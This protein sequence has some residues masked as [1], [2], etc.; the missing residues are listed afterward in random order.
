[1]DTIS[2]IRAEIERLKDEYTDIAIDSHYGTVN[3]NHVVDDLEQLL[4]FLDTIESEELME[5]EKEVKPC[6]RT[7]NK[8]VEWSKTPEGRAAYEKVAEEMRN[9]IAITNNPDE[10]ENPMQKGLEVD[11]EKEIK[12][13]CRGYWINDY[14]EQELGKHDIEN[15]ARHFAQWQKEQDDRLTDIIYQQGIEK[16]KDEMREQMFKKS[17]EADIML[18]LHDKTGDVSLHTGYLPKELGIKCDDKVRII[19]IKEEN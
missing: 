14:H 2:K 10:S 6:H 19:I 5:K 3:A 13:T 17:V 11:L 1:M 9:E 15:I 12:D 7:R 16:G 4:S 18:T 8:L